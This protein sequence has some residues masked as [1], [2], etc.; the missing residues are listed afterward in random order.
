[1]RAAMVSVEEQDEFSASRGAGVAAITL[2]VPWLETSSTDRLEA[3]H[4]ST[5][6][7]G[8]RGWISSVRALAHRRVAI[9]RKHEVWCP[10][11]RAASPTT[12]ELH[13][14]SQCLGACDL[15]AL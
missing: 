14:H 12:D 13:F 11:G 1:M 8:L 7:R 4:T 3:L 10:A 5:C 2:D 6:G 15:R 9:Q